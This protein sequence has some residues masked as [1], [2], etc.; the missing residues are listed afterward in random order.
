MNVAD[1]SG[2]ELDYWMYQHACKVMEQSSSKDEF[3]KGYSNGQFHFSSDKA[4]L[5]DLMETYNINIQR[6]AGEWLASTDGNSFY[7]DTPLMAACRLIVA[8]TFGK[9][10][11]G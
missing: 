9:T 1:L 4:L 3:D 2:E 6:L 5:A 11:S 7:G 8:L 10:V